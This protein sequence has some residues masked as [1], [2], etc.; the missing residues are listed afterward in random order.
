M[1]DDREWSDRIGGIVGTVG[2]RVGAGGE[3]LEERVEMLGLM[4]SQYIWDMTLYTELTSLPYC[5]LAW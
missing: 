3:D 5:S 4:V 1:V 2:E